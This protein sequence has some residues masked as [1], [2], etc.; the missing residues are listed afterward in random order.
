[1]SFNFACQTTKHP[2]REQHHYLSTG[3]SPPSPFPCESHFALFFHNLACSFSFLIGRLCGCP[4]CT[5]LVCWLDGLLF[6]QVAFKSYSSEHL[7][8]PLILLSI[9]LPFLQLPDISQKPTYSSSVLALPNVVISLMGHPT[10]WTHQPLRWKLSKKFFSL[11]EQEIFYFLGHWST[12]SNC[13]FVSRGGC[14]FIQGQA[15]NAKVV[16]E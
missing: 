7:S 12:T 15:T 10:Q 9:E 6:S 5:F 13:Y 8:N 4:V 3:K 2:W 1:M 14:H 11:K 16:R